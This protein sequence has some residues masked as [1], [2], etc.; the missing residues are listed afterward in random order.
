VK[1]RVAGIYESEEE[2]KESVENLQVEGH[3]PEEIIIV[4][5]DKE[6]TDWLR[7]ETSAKTEKLVENPEEIEES[8]EEKMSFM[9]KIKTAFKG[10]TEFSGDTSANDAKEP[11]NFTEHGFPED[12]AERYAAEINKGNIVILAPAASETAADQPAENEASPEPGRSEE[13]IGS[14]SSSEGDVKFTEDKDSEEKN[15]GR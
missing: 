8:P 5:N 10:Q 6:K 12:E 2:A 14:D 13:S 4:V 7:D 3:R 11:F 1:R 9:E 15:P